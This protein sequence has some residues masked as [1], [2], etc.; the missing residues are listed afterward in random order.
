MSEK[1]SP[2]QDFVNDGPADDDDVIIELTDEVKP[3][4]EKNR[5]TAPTEKPSLT[6]DEEN[7]NSDGEEGVQPEADSEVDED[8]IIASAIEESLGP[9]EDDTIS[10]PEELELFSDDA[11]PTLK[12]DEEPDDTGNDRFD[13]R[14]EAA[15][16]MENDSPALDPEEE[17]DL[18]YEGNETDTDLF[19]VEDQQPLEF[20]PAE[21]LPDLASQIEIDLDDDDDEQDAD[22]AGVND[23][24][25]DADAD[26]PA[27]LAADSL[28]DQQS[29]EESIQAVDDFDFEDGQADEFEPVIEQPD[30]AVS[31]RDPLRERLDLLEVT[32]KET[33]D[34][35]PDES[36]SQLDDDFEFEVENGDEDTV[37]PLNG[38]VEAGTQPDDDI[39]E[40]TEFDEYFPA[41]D[42]NLSEAAEVLNLSEDQEDDFIELIDV[43]EDP[44]ADDEEII[45]FEDP[46]TEAVDDDINRFFSEA[47]EEEAAFAE[48]A[49]GPLAD[50]PQPPDALAPEFLDSELAVASLPTDPDADDSADAQKTPADD[51][52]AV[53][54]PA[55]LT[56]DQIETAIERVID[57]KFSARI[58][59]IIYDVI[60]KAVTREIKRLKENLFQNGGPD[61][62]PEGPID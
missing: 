13:S 50:E 52:A 10:L 24:Q 53:P 26:I 33:L 54:L 23:W 55:D 28:M 61:D 59:S 12:L 6:L 47:I 21:D 17:I 44:A 37:I 19:A 20:D 3:Q 16:E 36:T 45:N 48:T 41:D 40:I 4:T 34:F 51:P 42:E 35:E 11:E 32:P 43:E 8:E 46:Q 15:L 25:R 22:P 49:S 9:D 27:P 57:E 2:H 7:L 62:E 18:E 14:G 30:D 58:E 29:R 39:I 5:E 38:L 56:S 1:Q 60:E 31:S